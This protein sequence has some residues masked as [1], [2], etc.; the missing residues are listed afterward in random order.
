MAQTAYVRIDGKYDMFVENGYLGIYHNNVEYL[1]ESCIAGDKYNKSTAAGADDLFDAYLHGLCNVGFNHI[2]IKDQPV[3][4]MGFYEKLGDRVFRFNCYESH[5]QQA[6]PTVRL[7]THQ[8]QIAQLSEVIVEM[9]KHLS[10]R[11]I[12]VSDADLQRA[13]ESMDEVSRC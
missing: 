8:Q 6:H 3:I 9:T 2:K 4:Q 5:A 12:P 1:S 10:Q 11:T 13:A 7:L